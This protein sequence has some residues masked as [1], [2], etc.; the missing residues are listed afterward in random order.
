VRFDVVLLDANLRQTL[1]CMRSLGRAGY[2]TAAL[3]WL[4]RR[5]T[6]ATAS[7]WCAASHR[8]ADVADDAD[9]FV[10]DVLAFLRRHSCGVLVPSHD[11]TIAAFRRRRAEIEREV[12]LALPPEPAL[13]IGVD[14]SLTLEVAERLGIGIPRGGYISSPGEVPGVLEAVGLPAVVKPVESWADSGP[15]PVRLRCREVVRVEE[16]VAAAERI[17]AVGGRAMLQEWAPGAR[18]AVSFLYQGGVFRAE[19]AQV[20][21]RMDPPI[22]GSSVLRESI[23]VAPDVGW[24]GRALV[25]AIGLEGYSEVEFRRDAS[26]RPLVMEVNPRLSASVEVAVRAGVDF[27]R[28]LYTWA[29]GEMVEAVPGYRVGQRMRWL[30]GDIHWLASA[31]VAPGRPD[32][33]TRLR[34]LALFTRDFFR[35]SSYDY[36]DVQDL[37]PAWVAASSYTRD[38]LAQGPSGMARRA[39]A[40]RRR[41]V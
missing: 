25:R 12:A 16:A 11:G 15:A 22:G 17:C 21:Y 34:A 8:V 32:A 4:P 13:R 5:M 35:R 2:S 37:R 24:A 19:F 9:R 26:G 14:K 36:L 28:L 7:R 6:P 23:P 41:A 31:L 33:P 40:F 27:P 3:T 30:G 39:A 1:V 10:D 18:E 38:V 20:A 29:R